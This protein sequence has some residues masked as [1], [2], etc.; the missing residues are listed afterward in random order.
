MAKKKVTPAERER[1]WVEAM[2][3]TGGNKTQSAVM[4]G[5]K[6]GEAAKKAGQRMSTNV[7]VAKMLKKRQKQVLDKAADKAQLT[8]D[9]VLLDLAEAMRFDPAM[10]YDDTGNLLPVKQMP[11]EV[12]RHLE[13]VETDVIKLGEKGALVTSKVKF[14]KKTATRDQA[15][16]HLGLFEKDNRQK[17]ALPPIVVKFV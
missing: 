5:Y 13:G 7:H 10:L 14:A 1:L 2:I 4:A 16:R 15:M 9:E 6:P 17:P 8:V 11:P 12:R 3:T